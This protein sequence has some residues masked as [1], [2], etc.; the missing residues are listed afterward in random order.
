MSRCWQVEF[1]TLDDQYW[2][3]TVQAT[4]TMARC[5]ARNKGLREE[6]G[7]RPRLL[8]FGGEE[9]DQSDTFEDIGIVEGGARLIIGERSTR[10]FDASA[11]IGR[12]IDINNDVVENLQAQNQGHHAM[13]NA[14]V[15]NRLP[16]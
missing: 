14:R 16:G 3:C 10:H 15:L 9:I 8:F 12:M 2:I 1:R 5:I 11:G 6:L 4:D 7:R 13:E